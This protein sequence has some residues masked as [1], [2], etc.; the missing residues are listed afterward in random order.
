MAPLPPL[1]VLLVAALLGP[2]MLLFL[3]SLPELMRRNFALMAVYIRVYM[4]L[5]GPGMSCVAETWHVAE[6]AHA[7]MRVV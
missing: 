3:V 1:L 7:C 5:A 4:A 6:T 2:R